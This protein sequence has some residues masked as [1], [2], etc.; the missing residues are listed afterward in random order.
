[1]PLRRRQF[2]PAQPTCLDICL[3]VSDDLENRLIGL[4][5]LTVQIPDQNP[6]HI[7]VDEPSDL[8]LTFLKIAIKARVFQRDRRLRRQQ[9]QDRI[10][11]G[12]N[13]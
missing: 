13:V 10:R 3:L 9:F 6:N 11:A 2:L 4:L 8:R 7:R 12:V 1:M 5:N